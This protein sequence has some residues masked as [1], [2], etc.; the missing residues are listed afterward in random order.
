MER[1]TS[2]SSIGNRKRFKHFKVTESVSLDSRPEYRRAWL[3]SSNS[4]VPEAV[5]TS[6]N[7]L[8]SRMLNL[9]GA[10]LLLVLPARSDTCSVI[11]EGHIVDALIIGTL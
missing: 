3:R 10:N 1:Q 7:Q 2:T 6:T 5:C 9:R 11:E 4:D 8:S